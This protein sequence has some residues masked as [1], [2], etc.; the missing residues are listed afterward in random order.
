MKEKL[1]RKWGLSLEDADRVLI[2]LRAKKWAGG[3]V[4]ACITHAG[5]IDNGSSDMIGGHNGYW[6]SNGEQ[7]AMVTNSDP[8]WG[9]WDE[10]AALTCGL[11]WYGS[12]AEMLI[13]HEI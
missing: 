13:R 6:I 3:E 1:A 7:Y 12:I 2:A 9:D 11:D 8:I 5:V 4:L 10:D